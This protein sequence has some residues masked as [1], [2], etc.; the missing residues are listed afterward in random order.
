M[1]NTLPKTLRK[2]ALRASD[3]PKAI[4]LLLWLLLNTFFLLH[5][6]IFLQGESAKYID[7]ARIFLAT[8][9]PE[10]ANFWLYITQI[11]LVAGCIKF[12]LGFFFAV[13]VQLVFN[14]IATAFFYETVRYI[15]GN[16]GTAFIATLLLLANY[17]YQEFNTFLYTE[18]LFYSFT[19]IL[20]CYL[21]HV[22]DLTIKRLSTVTAMLLIICVTR[23]TGLLFLPPVFLYLF[24]VFFRNMPTWK[25]ISLLT[26][27]A[28]LFLCLLNVAIG[29]GGGLDFML[30]FRDERIICGVPTLPSFLPI[31][32]APNGNSLYGLLYYITHNAPQFIKMAALRSRAFFGLYRSYYSTGHNIYLIVFFG[33]LYLTVIASLRYWFKRNPEILWY[34]ISAIGLNWLTVILSCDDW[35]N[36]FFLTI[37]PFLIILAM[38]SLQKLAGSRSKPPNER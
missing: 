17:F 7:Q 33:V 6:G 19:L 20:S 27:L 32:T 18:S 22:R 30:P 2:P 9:K 36:R 10:S 28:A 3:K 38:P 29:T 16:T 31:K 23:P 15:I 8:G 14:L 37:S 25:K 21:I 34:I 12:H 4:L 1:T 13:L 24:L 35:H 5:R 26:I 11:I